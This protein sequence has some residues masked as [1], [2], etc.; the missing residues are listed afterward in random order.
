MYPSKNFDKCGLEVLCNTKIEDP[1][2]FL[3]TPIT[4]PPAPPRKNLKTTYNFYQLTVGQVGEVGD[5]VVLVFFGLCSPVDLV[6]LKIIFYFTSCLCMGRIVH[7][8]RGGGGR[9]DYY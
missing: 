2:D 7:G 9:Y 3:T 5:E 4:P 1:P 6:G 8:A